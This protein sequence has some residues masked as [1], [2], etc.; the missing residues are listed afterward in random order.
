MKFKKTDWIAVAI[1]LATLI[2]LIIVYPSL[3]AQVPVNWGFDGQVT[4]GAKSTLWIL[5]GINAALYPLFFIIPKIDPKGKSYNKVDGFYKNFRIVM[6][7]FLTGILEITIF[8]ATDA[9]RFEVGK[10]ANIGVALLLIFI[11]NYLPKCKQSFT[12]GI[13][14]MWTLADE[15]VWNDT[16]RIGGIAFVAAGVITLIVTLF[17]P[18]KLYYIISMVVV[19][20]AVIG[21]TVYSYLSY[22]KY[23]KDN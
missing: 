2:Q 3:P 23:N 12:L 14:T 18:E 13:K 11:G 22:R 15:R 21:T 7:V 20:A 5:V 1:I 10:I 9:Q 8:S 19:G 17:L 16:H 6:V 4:Y